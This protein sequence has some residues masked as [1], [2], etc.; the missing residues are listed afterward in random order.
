MFCESG[1]IKPY[2]PYTQYYRI[3]TG[4]RSKNPRNLFDETKYT[5]VTNG[6]DLWDGFDLSKLEY[7]KTYTFSVSPPVYSFKIS[8]SPHGYNSPSFVDYGNKLSTFTWE[9]QWN[10][11]F[12]SWIKELYLFI[13]PNKDEFLNAETVKDYKIMINEGETA[14][15][16]YLQD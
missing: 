6:T 8:N 7:G 4:I 16:Y 10:P 14:E 1:E 11:N 12:G 2:E 15:P 5:E 9:H 3:R 13:K